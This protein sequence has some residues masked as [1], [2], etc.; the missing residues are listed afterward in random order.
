MLPSDNAYTIMKKHRLPLV[1]NGKPL[2]EFLSN[3]YSMYI[4][5]I[6]DAV[7]DIDGNFLQKDFYYKLIKLIPL[8]ER[9][10]DNIIELLR[11]YNRAN[12]S[13]LFEQLTMTVDE[14]K[15]Y[16][17]IKRIPQ[18][19]DSFFRIRPS[20]NKGF[21][22]ED[23]F[24][25]PMNER[26][27]I[28]PY[29]YSIAG[30]PCLYLS[31]GTELCW[32]ECGMPQEF[33]ISQYRFEPIDASYELLLID[34]SY[35][36]IM[37]YSSAVTAY[38]NE[39]DKREQIDDYLLKYF[40]S[41]LLRA[42]CSITATDRS[43]PFIEEYIIPQL[44]LLWVRESD[45]FKG[46]IYSTAS[47]NEEANEWNY[48][49]IVLPA[50]EISNNYCSILRQTFKITEP[51]YCDVRAVFQA[52]SKKADKVREYIDKLEYINSHSKPH[53]LHREI[54]SI[55]KSFILFYDSISSGN[56]SNPMPMYQMMDTINLFSYVISEHNKYFG[57]ESI[58]KD[59]Q[60][61]PS[62]SDDD[63]KDEFDNVVNEFIN[64]IKPILFD[65]WGYAIRISCD[66]S[67][68]QNSY[69]YIR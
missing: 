26:Y 19:M 35:K 7:K 28:K 36:P 14:I 46:V 55:C 10:C 15:E 63:A 52:Y 18:G 34:F 40:V 22:R 69:E 53:Y 31:T 68:D 57:I 38:Y 5:D 58:K 16:L 2:I 20:K 60:L 64:D 49:N 32:F 61:Y 44:L 11:L 48:N 51:V 3:Y 30:Y 1:G 6:K 62:L 13:T 56:Y 21:K 45:L 42:A 59:K 8:I 24:H 12:L 9:N 25:I 47:S 43:V 23:L 41:H 54:L 67:I 37:L 33:S 29:R 27:K 17:Y 4:K 65:F 50:K 39:S 66:I